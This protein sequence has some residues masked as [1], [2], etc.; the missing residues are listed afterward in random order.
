MGVDD[1]GDEG[2]EDRNGGVVLCGDAASETRALCANLVTTADLLLI[3]Q[4]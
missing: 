3:T 1:V 4:A 2:E